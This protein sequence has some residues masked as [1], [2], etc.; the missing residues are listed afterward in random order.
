MIGDDVVALY[1]GN[2]I[3]V[4]DARTPAGSFGN[5]AG[6]SGAGDTTGDVC[7]EWGKAE[8]EELEPLR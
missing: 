4:R 5:A 2:G 3:E 1:Y 8:W 7:D 6:Q